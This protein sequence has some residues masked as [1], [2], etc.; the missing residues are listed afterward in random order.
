MTVYDLIF[1]VGTLFIFLYEFAL[2][3]IIII[4]VKPRGLNLVWYLLI[5]LFYTLLSIK[6]VGMNIN[7]F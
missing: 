7:I 6:Y 5:T 3:A 1:K 2:I 4:T